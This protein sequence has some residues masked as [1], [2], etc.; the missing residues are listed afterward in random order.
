M[1]NPLV[2]PIILVGSVIGSFAN[3]LVKIGANKYSFWRLWRS[4]YLWGGLVL[5]GLSVL[6][7]VLVL[8]FEEL[9]VIYPLVSM[10]YIW[11]TIFSIKYLGE[12]MN[13]WKY[14][15]LIGI[16]LGIVLIGVG[17]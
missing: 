13:K 10:S 1:V 9:S 14:I 8:R 11:T 7:Y 2:F 5:Y 17:S 3:L 6:A 12:K 4:S 16:I 15:G